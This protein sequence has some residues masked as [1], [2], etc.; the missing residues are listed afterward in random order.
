[1]SEEEAR[2]RLA[3]RYDELVSTEKSLHDGIAELQD[4]LAKILAEPKWK[5]K[6]EQSGLI[7]RASQ[8]AANVAGLHRELAELLLVGGHDPKALPQT[9]EALEGK[10]VQDYTTFQ[11]LASHATLILQKLSGGQVG[12]HPPGPRTRAEPDALS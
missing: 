2:K 7:S 12:A 5:F 4:S 6:A 10:F 8:A 9:F 11:L 3:R 1:M